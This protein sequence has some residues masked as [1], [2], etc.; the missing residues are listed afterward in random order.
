MYW[1]LYALRMVRLKGEQ[2]S[3]I[4]FQSGDSFTGN[5]ALCVSYAVCKNVQHSLQHSDSYLIIYHS[6]HKSFYLFRVMHLIVSVLDPF[7]LT[8]VRLNKGSSCIFIDDNQ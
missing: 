4:D 3:Q 2:D 6:N 7:R 8:A 5:I 1:L